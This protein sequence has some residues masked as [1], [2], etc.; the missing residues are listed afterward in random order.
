MRKKC[1]TRAFARIPLRVERTQP[2]YYFGW[3]GLTGSKPAD[4]YAIARLGVLDAGANH[5]KGLLVEGWVRT[6][7]AMPL[8]SYRI[9][10]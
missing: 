8:M 5:G 4:A 1:G 2:S 6:H 9:S 10:A 3:R 7:G